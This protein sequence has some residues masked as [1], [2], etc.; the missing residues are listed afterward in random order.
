LSFG[1]QLKQLLLVGNEKG[2]YIPSRF[3]SNPFFFYNLFQALWG[4]DSTIYKGIQRNLDSKYTLK[5]F[6]DQN[7]RCSFIQFSN[8]SINAIG[9]FVGSVL[10][11]W[12]CSFKP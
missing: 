7:Y 12:S 3:L 8:N 9:V 1:S 4:R 10:P 2:L 6:H 5:R 11:I